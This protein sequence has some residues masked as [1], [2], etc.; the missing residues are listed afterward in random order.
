M[1][2][3]S[4]IFVVLLTSA[5]V[6]EAR[7]SDT[8]RLRKKWDAAITVAAAEV[9]PGDNQTLY[10]DDWFFQGRYAV[11][12]GGYWTENLKTEFEYA[13]F[14]EGSVVM[15]DYKRIPG[16]PYVYPYHFDSTHRLEQLQLRMTYQFGE[17]S[18]VHPYISGGVFVARDAWGVHTEQQFFNPT[19]RPQDRVMVVDEHTWPGHRY[20]NDLGFVAATGAKMYFSKNGFVNAGF[21]WTGGQQK[22]ISTLIGVGIDF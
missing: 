9:K 8:S 15:Q 5:G 10:Q 19:G 7:Q 16:S 2:K 22:S 14:G 12:V 4:W 3:F 6:A 21:N 1:R 11:Q 13:R 18:W 17:N 20:D